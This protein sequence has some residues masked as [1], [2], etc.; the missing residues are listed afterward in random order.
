MNHYVIVQRAPS[1]FGLLLAAGFILW[2]WKWVLLI[3][4]TLAALVLIYYLVKAI[5]QR[6]AERAAALEATRQRA[7]RQLNAW[8][9]GDP[10]ATFGWDANGKDARS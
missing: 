10:R 6:Q 9:A 1:L 5:A 4:G 8:M 7:D 2:L 3:I